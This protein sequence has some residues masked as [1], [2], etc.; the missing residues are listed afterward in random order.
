MS[1]K[2]EAIKAAVAA[3]NIRVYDGIMDDPSDS[4]PWAV[5]IPGSYTI[6]TFQREEDAQIVFDL[7]RP[8]V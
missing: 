4:H 8:N 2:S 1:R 5:A 6:A 7:L 3:G